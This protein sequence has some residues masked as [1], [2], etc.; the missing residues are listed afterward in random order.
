MK[1]RFM[2]TD[3]KPVRIAPPLPTIR[4]ARAADV[5]R[6]FGIIDLLID[7]PQ[8]V[9]PFQNEVDLQSI[10]P[11][12]GQI[13]LLS[14]PSGAG[15]TSL[16]RAL[17]RLVQPIVHWIDLAAIELPAVPVV[18][19]FANLPILSILR[20]LSRV[21]LAEAWTYLRQ[22]AELSEG[23]R[24]R[25]KLAIAMEQAT[26]APSRKFSRAIIAADEFAAILDRITAFVVSRCVRKLINA[27]CKSR[28]PAAASAI[29][30]TS[31]DDL[32]VPLA[33]DIIVD[34]DFSRLRVIR[35]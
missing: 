31:H 19:C 25:L 4:S 13:L 26:S 3:E 33:P 14:G 24:C 27:D 21:G 7:S 6:M 5:A 11:L 28:G 22:P 12:P 8:P 1:S 16:L 10:L 23:Q 18:D 29:L 35:R 2:A 9:A 20:L 34:C 32:I 17:K 15:K 30:A